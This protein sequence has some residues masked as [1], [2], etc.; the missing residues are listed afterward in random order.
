MPQKTMTPPVAPLVVGDAEPFIIKQKLSAR[1]MAQLLTIPDGL[2]TAELTDHIIDKLAAL[3][4]DEGER[5][6]FTA[7]WDDDD[8]T[9]KVLTE[10]H[11]RV[12]EFYA[13]GRPMD[14]S[15]PS[16]GGSGTPA[17]GEPSTPDSSSQG[18]PASTLS[19]AT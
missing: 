8:Y 13:E 1:S 10:T 12:I 2:N 19:L 7:L 16:S 6:R 11:A 18:A 9:D 17:T 4:P 5:A 3:I 14:G 15:S